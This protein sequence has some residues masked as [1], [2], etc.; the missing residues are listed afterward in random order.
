MGHACD[1]GG[2]GIAGG[3]EGGREGGRDWG[4]AGGRDQKW[5]VMFL[6]R[7][8]VKISSPLSLPPSLPRWW[9]PQTRVWIPPCGRTSW[10]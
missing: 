4:M 10:T 8:Y 2:G 6:D 9:P 3:R 5:R 7:Q 1:F